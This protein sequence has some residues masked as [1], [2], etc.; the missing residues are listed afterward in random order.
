MKRDWNEIRAAL[1]SIE[2]DKFADYL[3]K[4]GEYFDDSLMSD[5]ERRAKLQ[6]LGIERRD[7]ILGHLELLVD[8][9]LVKGISIESFYGDVSI[10]ELQ[11]IRPRL[12]MRG[13]DLLEYLRSSKFRKGLKEYC[14]SIGTEITLDVIRYG[15]PSIIKMIEG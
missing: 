5:G 9:G 12:T 4:N 14:K 11:S 8:A 10:S 2:Q 3:G 15:F 13:Y 6:E 1:E 7:V